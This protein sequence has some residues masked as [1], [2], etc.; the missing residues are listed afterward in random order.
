[1]RLYVEPM[2]ALVVEV[3]EE[4]RVRLK[5]EQELSTPSLQERRAIL[6]SAKNEIEELTELIEILERQEVGKARS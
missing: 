6:Y 4:G 2:D 1:M 5:D 3:D